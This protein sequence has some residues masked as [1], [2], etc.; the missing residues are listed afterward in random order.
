M[1]ALFQPGDEMRV[2]V[3]VT[4]DK[5]AKFGGQVVHPV[6]S[7]F[8]LGQDAEWACRQFVLAMKDPGEEGVGSYL[9]VEHL[10]PALE[11]TQVT[12]TATL[13]SVIENR[14]RCSWTAHSADGRLL[15]RG[16]QEQRIVSEQSFKAL[17]Q[18]LR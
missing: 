10:A 11:G 18:S 12:V 8:A 14:V 17:L 7:T 2:E 16:E 4:P 3:R 5:L 1:T 15:A 9:S 6:Y 13:Q